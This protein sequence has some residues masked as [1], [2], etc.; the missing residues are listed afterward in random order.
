MQCTLFVLEHYLDG[1][2]RSTMTQPDRVS[3]III[4]S[5]VLQRLS[6]VARMS[7]GGVITLI[8]GYYSNDQ[9]RG[10]SRSTASAITLQH[11]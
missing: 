5:V 10:P 9:A 2:R 4:H 6:L 1:R 3:V 11:V 8:R 7:A